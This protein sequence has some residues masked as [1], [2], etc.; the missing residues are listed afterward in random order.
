MTKRT[1]H[2]I[3]IK[4]KFFTTN[5]YHTS[6]KINPTLIVFF[7]IFFIFIYKN[8]IKKYINYHKPLAFQT[9]IIHFKN[10]IQAN[11]LNINNQKVFLKILPSCHS[12]IIKYKSKINIKKFLEYLKN[13]A[14]INQL[15][16]FIININN[17]KYYIIQFRINHTIKKIEIQNYQDLQIP[18]KL[19]INIFKNQLG[20]PI[21]YFKVHNSINKIYAWYI[22]NGFA[23][24]YIKF[25]YNSQLDT[26][27]IQILE[28]QIIA[29]SLICKSK[30]IL[31]L[32]LIK[33]IDKIII[34]ELDI[35]KK[36]IF[37]KKKI[38]RGIIYLKK[39][40][41]LKTCSYKIKKYKQGLLLNI[42]YSIPINDYG[43]IYNHASKHMMSNLLLYNALNY[44]YSILLSTHCHI[45]HQILQ[46][47]IK[48]IS[49]VNQLYHIYLKYKY[50]FNKIYDFKYIKLHYYLHYINSN[51]KINLQTIN[52]SPEFEFLIL[53]PYITFDK[54][55]L[56]FIKLNI[57]Q[58]IYKT[59]R[60]YS[61]QNKI[62]N[63]VN[64]KS[65]GHFIIINQ[66]IFKNFNY[67]FKY[68]NTK[69]LLTE[70]FL[71]LNINNFKKSLIETTNIKIYKKVLRQRITSI[72]TQVKYNNLKCKKFLEPGKIFIL[73]FLF[74]KPQKIITKH[75]LHQ[76]K[77]NNDIQL[78][79]YQIIV[80]PNYLKYIKKNAINIFINI[81]SFIINNN[82]KNILD[83]INN[84]NFQIYFQKRYTRIIQNKLR[85]IYQIEY[86]IS[87][88]EFFSYYIF[89]NCNNKLYDKNKI[90]K[91]NYIMGLGI[92][93]NIP[94]KTL[95]K[96]RFEYKI[97]KYKMNHYQ[98]RLFSSCT[99]NN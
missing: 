79:Y 27:H 25:K 40:Q 83:D 63:N 22:N 50:N 4:Y 54:I 10:R 47:F 56:D 8:N 31:N 15:D 82:Y 9:Y 71:Y 41:I 14:I 2:N 36:S 26:L 64:I 89:G 23:Y 61:Q 30:N 37:N 67:K 24:T 68:K 84:I 93:I 62:I 99:N 34:K 60:I 52:N 76:D 32:N 97:N 98:L 33:K 95:P 7:Y 28:G 73:E 29:N 53:I 88:S 59:K 66:K 11:D 81:N 85:D 70:K 20:I 13:T 1:A 55:I 72:N 19:L 45:F 51:Y 57:Y 48:Q 96:I 17:L 77:F 18:K 16:Y 12:K 21:N 80:L 69:N 78:K 75:I 92:Q 35:S 6:K 46:K 90:F 42:E 94:I 65:Q 44:D 74:L 5:I 87:L 58:K 3:Y 43:Y 91:H 39:L 86:H 38:D 49:Q